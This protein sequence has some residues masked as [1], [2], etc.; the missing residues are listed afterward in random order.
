MNSKT[1]S[2]SSV[3]KWILPVLL[4][5]L[6]CMAP[7][8]TDAFNILMTTASGTA[9][10]HDNSRPIRYYINLG[11][12][13]NA[14]NREDLIQGIRNAFQ[15]VEDHPQ[16]NVRFE[17]G[18]TTTQLPVMDDLNIVYLDS[19][20]TY[21]RGYGV[22]FNYNLD[23]AGIIR[24]A[25]IGLNGTTHG[26]DPFTNLYALALHE[27][28][29]FLGLDHSSTGLDSAVYNNTVNLK[30]SADDIA[31]LAT[32]YPNPE[33]PLS[34][35]TGTITGRVTKATGEG[36]NARLVAYDVSRP[37]QPRTVTRNTNADGTFEL[38]GLPPGSYRVVAETRQEPFIHS[39][40]GGGQVY[41]VVGGT[42]FTDQGV[43]TQGQPMPRLFPNSVD[44]S[45]YHPR[46]NQVYLT[47]SLFGPIYVINLAGELMS[48][49]AVAAD[50][51]A[52]SPDGT[53][54]YAVDQVGRRLRIIDVDPGST[55]LHQV[56]KEITGLPFQPNHLVVTT[57]NIAYVVTNGGLSIVVIDM[58]S[59]TIL[60]TIVTGKYNQ[61][62]SLS[63]DEKTAYVGTYY[64]GP[65][66]VIEIDIDPHSPTYN[67]I[68]REK[69][70]GH[71]SAWHV[72]PSS[73]GR[74]LFHLTNAGINVWDTSDYTL[75][76]QINPGKRGF[77][78][79]QTS[80]G[81]YLVFLG[82]DSNE[83]RN[84]TLV[85]VDTQTLEVVDE[86][87]LG[88]QQYFVLPGTRTG[89]VFVAGHSGLSRIFVLPKKTFLPLVARQH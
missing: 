29:H 65:N 24:S 3:S 19:N 44:S 38:V 33:Y 28:C 4:A 16:I 53:R 77:R 25:D 32:L 55:T 23:P 54:L 47:P 5:M 17:Y 64:G 18:G 42:G 15:E 84:D 50:D 66:T 72:E 21:V 80:D 88:G 78:F 57:N 48:T 14:D 49:I 9:Y 13:E 31:G 61:D 10:R 20:Q 35:V 79:T 74:Y 56:L 86:L 83:L 34:S 69:P 71:N 46:S 68:L 62:I 39:Y 59:Y 40:L 75:I 51:L 30:L 63:R 43:V 73:D 82:Q 11:N 85:V 41:T 87:L 22:T 81:R 1:Q 67:T 8:P 37:S 76:K 27:L 26:G 89:E 60:A 70:I 12:F 36:Q 52:F 7:E 2:S 6:L 58:N 45:I